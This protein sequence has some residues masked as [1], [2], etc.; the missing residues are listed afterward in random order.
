MMKDKLIKLDED[1]FCF[2]DNKI[3]H[4]NKDSIAVVREG[5]DETIY[6]LKYKVRGFR[7]YFNERKMILLVIRVGNNNKIV[8]KKS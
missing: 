3:Y 4:Y 5:K 8:I 6:G 2:K 1:G 7:E